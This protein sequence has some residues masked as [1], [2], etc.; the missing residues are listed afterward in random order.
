MAIRNLAFAALFSFASMAAQTTEPVTG[1]IRGSAIR[2][3]TPEARHGFADMEPLRKVVG[4]ARIVSLGEA[5]HGSREFFQLKHRMLEFLA[6]RMGF[7]IFSIEANMPEAY[8]LNDFVLRGEGDPVKLIKGMYFWTWD[9]QEVLDM[10]LWM[11]EFNKSGKGRV[12]FTGFDMQTPTV[13]LNIVKDFVAAADP[14]YTPTL[15]KAGELALAPPPTPQARFGTASG[16]FPLDAARGKRVRFTGYIKTENVSEYA[17]FWWRVDGASKT[18]SL[19]F[20]N[21]EDRAPK[22]TTDWKQYELEIPVAKEATAIYFGPLLAGSGTAWFDNLKVE[23]DGTPYTSQDF[24]FDFEG[25]ALKGLTM[26]GMAY[27]SRIDKEVFHDGKQSLRLWRAAPPVNPNVKTVDPKLASA[28]WKKVVE[29]LETSRAT[30]TKAAAHD[31]D[32]SIQNARV[33]LQCMQMRANEV[34]RDASMAA[35]VKWILDHSPDAKIVLWAHNGH[36]NTTGYGNYAPM[37][38][39]LRRMYGDQMVVFGFAF[40]QGSF[41]AIAQGGSGGLKDHTVPPAPPGS[42]DATLA[43]SGISLF[44]LDLRQAPKSGPVADWLKEPHKTR[45]I[46]A[47]YPEDAPFALMADQVAPEN[48]NVILFVEKTTAARKNP[49]PGQ[50]QY[51]ATAGTDGLTEYRDPEH[52]VSLKLPGGWKI[53]QAVR[54]SDHA[55]T[56]QLTNP[57]AQSFT[58]LWFRL[59]PDSRKLSQD[60]AYRELAANPDAKVVQRTGEGMPDYKI[61]AGTLRQRTIG[62]LPALSCVADFTTGG[63]PMAEYLVWIRGEKATALFFGRTAA[64]AFDAFRESFDRVIE[65]AK[66]P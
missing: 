57:L 13:A 12:E 11:R 62:G 21:L 22:G 56:V 33:V 17:G 64:A 49:M 40:N 34:T 25:P 54:L 2:L 35:N 16:S 10:V 32:W 6:T 9:T 45:T 5:T 66:I 23:L 65:T 60:D 59:P 58:A 47:L 28:E 30:Y 14:D 63:Q 36:V 38:A 31:I 4:N 29:H 24:D 44:A 41:Q 19:A 61:R 52:A 15:N 39:D 1:W 46:G 18:G 53:P 42:L 8:K 51:V 20:A 26:N 37:G 3:T 43:A 7:S 27:Q 55:T 48:F 50:I